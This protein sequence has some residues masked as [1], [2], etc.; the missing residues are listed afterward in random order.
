MS[1]VFQWL[2][3]G[4]VL[5]SVLQLGALPH[6]SGLWG[7][8]GSPLNGN[9]VNL[10][11]RH[12]FWKC[13]CPTRGEC[14]PLGLSGKKRKDEMRHSKFRESSRDWILLQWP[15]P[16]EPWPSPVRPLLSSKGQWWESG[17]KVSTWSTVSGMVPGSHL[18]SSL[19]VSYFA[20][21]L[22]ATGMQ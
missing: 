15:G 20:W 22:T 4:G 2:I 6:G 7:F 5:H 17:T 13:P 9:W 18:L 3:L 1:T 11:L 8:E 21:V 12:W 14:H 10:E 16:A 19:P